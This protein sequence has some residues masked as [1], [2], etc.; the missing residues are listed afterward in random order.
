M[1]AAVG[2][3]VAAGA[4]A[5]VG[6]GMGAIVA[7]GAA[8]AAGVGAAVGAGVSS[9]PQPKIRKDSAKRAAM[10]AKVVI[11]EAFTYCNIFFSSFLA[12]RVRIP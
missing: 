4:G 8:M 12:D 1:R 10:A 11:L 9:S 3:M 2:A 5:A 6:A 7:A